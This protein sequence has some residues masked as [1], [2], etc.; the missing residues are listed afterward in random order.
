MPADLD[1]FVSHI[2]Q[3]LA[4]NRLVLP[5]LPAVVYK[6]REAVNDERNGPY[7][8]AKLIQLDPTLAARLIQIANSPAY[9]PRNPIDSIQLA[10]GHLGLAATR[11]LVTC[12][13]MHN[14]YQ[15]NT[16]SIN[17]QVQALWRHSCHV[18]AIC[19]VLAKIHPGFQADKA[20]LAGLLHDIGELPVLH[21]ATDYPELLQDPA[22]LTE[23]RIR[24]RAE[25]AGAILQKW[26]FDQVLVDAAVEAQNWQRDTHAKADYVDLVIVAQIHSYF[27]TAEEAHLPKLVEVPA[28]N[29]L[30][31]GKIG[32]QASLE[33]LQE[34]RTEIE[35]VRRYLAA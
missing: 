15:V 26:N 31:I 14:V 2:H 32:P 5:S 20:L 4:S 29:K 9:R 33:L 28:F 30:S 25:L 27:G 22:L 3:E 19:H 17:K 35:S 6:I 21:Y 10:I 7:Q 23:L 11:D 34:A 24:L 18:A 1:R 12:L 16:E 8:L 13:V